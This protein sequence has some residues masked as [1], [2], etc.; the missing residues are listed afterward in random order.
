[1]K[2]RDVPV[3]TSYHL[4]IPYKKKTMHC[5]FYLS[6]YI[7]LLILY[8]SHLVQLDSS[9][10]R[11]N[12]ILAEE[13]KSEDTSI[14]PIQFTSYQIKSLVH[15]WIN[16]DIIFLDIFFKIY[17]S[18]LLP[19]ITMNDESIWMLTFTLIFDE[20]NIYINGTYLRQ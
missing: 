15:M 20:R 1:M 19:S 12:P 3:L 2:I 8:L 6:F 17:F 16:Q 5:R 18:I 11:K 7:Y 10:A 14:F 4:F 9:S 13:F